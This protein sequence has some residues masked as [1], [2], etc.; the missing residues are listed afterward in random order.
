M[1]IEKEPTFDRNGYPTEDDTIAFIEGF[2]VLS[3]DIP[4]KACE[5]LLDFCTECWSYPKMVKVDGGTYTFITGG[6]SGNESIIVAMQE[7]Y[8]FWGLT[9]YS[10]ERGGKH[11][12][13]I[14]GEK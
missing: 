4:S 14:P 9:W 1:L 12:F 10:S 7:N 6:W 5:A 11:V 2:D 8:V 13:K 3:E